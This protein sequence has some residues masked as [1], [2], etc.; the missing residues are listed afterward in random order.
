MVDPSPQPGKRRAA[1]G[2]V[3][4]LLGKLRR[5]HHNRIGN[6]FPENESFVWDGTSVAN[7]EHGQARWWGAQGGAANNNRMMRIGCAPAVGSAESKNRR[8]ASTRTR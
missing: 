3:P 1:A 2:W 8:A 5:R 4:Q 6:Y 7:L